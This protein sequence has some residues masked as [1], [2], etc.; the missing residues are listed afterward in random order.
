MADFKT[1]LESLARGEL[2]VE[3]LTKQLSKLLEQSP[4]YATKM[5]AHLDEAHDQKTIDDAVYTRLKKQINQYRRAH[6]AQTE[7]DNAGAESTVFAQDDNAADQQSPDQKTQVMEEK[8][9]VEK[10]ESDTAAFDVTGAS[11]MSGVDV[12]IS[13]LDDTGQQSITSA[14][15]PAGTEWSDPSQGGYTPGQDLGPGSVIKH[16]FKLLDV[17]GVGGMGKVYKGI[18][19]L[20]EEARDRH[21]YVAIKLL[22]EDFKDHPEAFI[23]LQR[24]SSRQ[25]KLAHPNIATVYDF[26]RIGGP[27]TPVFITMELM[28]GMELKDYIKKEVRKRGGLPF[29][30]AF[31]IIK[32]LGDALIYAHNRGLAHSDFKPGNAFLCN[33]GTVKTLD[34]GIARAVKNPTTGEA[35]KTLFDPGKLGALTP[36]YASLEMLEGEEPDT[37][38]DIYALGCVSYELLTGKHPFNKLPA[39]KAMENNLVP[40][41]V[42]GLK[43]KQ[44]RAL[45]RSV[46]FH[47]KDRSPSVEHFIEE[48]EARFIWYK[49]PPTVAAIILL[50]IGIGATAPVLNYFHKQEINQVISDIKSGDAQTIVDRLAIIKGYEK[51]DQLAI[52]DE[53][54]DAIQ[55]YYQN[56]ISKLIDTSSENY[57]FP[58]AEK[59]LDQIQVYYPESSFLTKQKSL[60]EETR[61]QKLSELYLQVSDALK[62]A[63]DNEDP[64]VLAKIKPILDTIHNKI[65][66]NDPILKD[67]RPSG[68]YRTLA[69]K[70]FQLGNYEAALNLIQSGLALA[71]QDQQLKDT[72]RKINRA[73][74]LAGLQEKLGSVQGQ[75]TALSDFKE[76]QEDIIRLSELNTSDPLLS[77]LAINMQEQIE[78]EI[79]QM[80]NTGSRSDAE[81]MADEYGKLL[82]ALQLGNQ[83]TKIK[84]AH[85]QGE[86]RSK[87]IQE[88][89]AADNKEI[90][91][92]IAS[93]RLEDDTWKSN[94]LANFREL[95]SL[96]NEDPSI[97]TNLGQTRQKAAELYVAKARETLAEDRFD[98]ANSLI[99]SGEQLAPSFSEIRETRNTI[100]EARTAHEKKIRVDGLKSDFNKQI[101]ANQ[102]VKALEF[103]EDL[104]S[105]LPADDPFITTTGPAAITNSYKTLAINRSAQND[106]ANALK[107]A[108]EG[109]K[110]NAGDKEL[111]DLRNDYAA[112]VYIQELT[113]TFKS[114][115]SFNTADVNSKISVI[116]TTTKS[117]GFRTNSIKILTDR[118]NQLRT[119]DQNAAATL[120]QN[121]ATIFPNSPL[122]Q[123]KDEIRPEPWPQLE[124]ARAALSTGRLSEATSIQQAGA[125]AGFTGHPDF[126]AFSNELA[127]RKNQ[128]LESFQLYQSQKEAAGDNYDQ[129]NE[130]KRQLIRAQALWADNPDY[131]AA[132]TEIN[133]L[134][135]ANQPVSKKV[136]QREEV[137]IEEAVAKTEEP[138][139]VSEAWKP[140]SS[141]RECNSK[142]AG[143]GKR[144]KA[145]CYDLVNAGWRG[146]LMVVIPSGGDIQKP[147]AIGKYEISI[148]DYSKYCALTGRCKPITDKDRFDEPQTGI[149]LKDAENYAAW[150]SERTGKHYRLPTAEEWE[151]AANANGEQPRK[152]F[153]C[154]VAL[155]EKVIKGNGTVS[156]ISGQ[157]NGWGLK[158]YVGNVQEWVIDGNNT[159]KAR[160]GAFEDSFSN[161]DI[162]LER[163]H[164][165]HADDSTGFRLILDDVG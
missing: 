59:I 98:A 108:D 149:S 5:L 152:D 16:R 164:D 65:D 75:L 97:A 68:Q 57:D 146:P 14:T 6:A 41:P 33:D 151:Y 63:R 64:T 15:G 101:E 104:K 118:I 95:E 31:T 139:K 17:L 76:Y 32:Q 94:L 136:I 123:L 110:Y 135:T 37:R 82:T 111:Q 61:E 132:E 148:G 54:K 52:T 87:A 3:L 69:D 45:R 47:R 67:Q 36:A 29:D 77:S 22:N 162:S 157:Q 93:P 44:N 72:E 105:E 40:A 99:D 39:N 113:D 143:Y 53:A 102:V 140:Q 78:P 56:A 58:K 19:L 27:G 38:D 153:N 84:L 11:D 96:S 116:N 26:D 156:V 147:F 73:I 13:A 117:S 120:A 20:K 30:E 2:D 83:L 88:I 158:N 138:G 43:K 141:G 49:H 24:E 127:D 55:G 92:L 34:F 161:C 131:T 160:G 90:E 89:A 60:I 12:D 42:K 129:L 4:Q 133:K 128:A 159:V 124:T 109:L 79:S 10:Q 1:A 107:L 91:K 80:E 144:A 150:L 115:L 71:P 125:E 23:S 46:A 112:E 134:I 163:P 154:R 106:F 137:N 66:P 8:T 28:E 165:G 9:R 18:D 119:T 130:A 126:V 7:G 21:P 121:A 103:F 51:S 81:A 114:A 85:L 48:L 25:Q 142:L 70:Q 155:G 74:E 62:Q 145:I 122:A 35:E 100:A 50:T 86:E